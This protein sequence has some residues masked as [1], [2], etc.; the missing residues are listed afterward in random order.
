MEQSM[1]EKAS[2][3]NGWITAFF[4]NKIYRTFCFH[5][6]NENKEKY[7]NQE[8]IQLKSE[9]LD[10]LK[11]YNII[12]YK[13]IHYY[14]NEIISYT[15]CLNKSIYNDLINKIKNKEIELCYHNCFPIF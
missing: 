12:N 9:L 14:N 4:N 8:N 5:S 13:I 3:K 11:K 1:L 2:T 6:I 10:I 15:L 7:I